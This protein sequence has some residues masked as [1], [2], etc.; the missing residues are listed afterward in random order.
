MKHRPVVILSDTN[1]GLHVKGGEAAYVQ[2]VRHLDNTSPALVQAKT[3]GT[4]E[5]FARG[6]QDYLQAPLQPLMDN[7]QGVTYQTFEQDPVK[8]QKYEEVSYDVVT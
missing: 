2:Y 7:L 8:Y 5:N 1:A 3:A 4:V 6:Y